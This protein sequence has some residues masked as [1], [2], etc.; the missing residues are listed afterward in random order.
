VINRRVL[1]LRLRQE[2]PGPRPAPDLIQRLFL[3]VAIALL[4]AVLLLVAAVAELRSQ[5]EAAAQDQARRIL[6]D[7]AARQERMV[8]GMRQ[9]L[10]VLAEANSV[11]TGNLASCA[12]RFGVLARRIPDQ[13]VIGTADLEGWM[14][15]ST[16]ATPP[17]TVFIGDRRFHRLP[18]ETGGF[19]VGEYEPGSVLRPG[20]LPMGLPIRPVGGGEPLGTVGAALGAEWMAKELRPIGLPPGAELFVVDRKTA[21]SSASP[22]PTSARP[23][24]HRAPTPASRRRNGSGGGWPP[25]GK[26]AQLHPIRRR[27]RR[28]G[29]VSSRCPARTARRDSSPSSPTWPAPAAPRAWPSRSTPPRRSRRWRR[30]SGTG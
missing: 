2:H 23:S 29:R 7:A 16:A 14:L 1:S 6:A 18:L 9:T 3:L 21:S 28:P 30:R 11:Q 27:T 22:R 20:S 15:C 24:R 19:V 5:R 25:R 17:R 10:L 4:P 26:P 8:E 12:R 13:V